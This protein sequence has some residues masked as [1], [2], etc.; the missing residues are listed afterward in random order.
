MYLRRIEVQGFKSFP[1]KTIVEFGA[2]LTALVGPNG[3]GKSNIADAIRWALGEQSARM[4]RAQRTEDVI[5]GG[6]PKRSRSGMAEVTLVFDNGDGWLPLEYG[7]VSV[8]RRA[9]RSGENDYI[10]NGSSVRLRDLQDLL[11]T[12]AMGV[13]GQVVVGQGQIDA[14]LRLKPEDRRTFI[15]EAAGVSRHYAK[16][17]EARR[18]LQRT[19]RNL[20]R[21]RDLHI[22]LVP[23][24]DQLKLQSEVA[25]RSRDLGEELESQTRDLLQ[26]R[27]AQAAESLES[28][29]LAQRAASEKL[30]TLEAARSLNTGD[31]ADHAVETARSRLAKARVVLEKIRADMTETSAGSRLARQ[32]GQFGKRAITAFSAREAGSS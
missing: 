29:K 13:N 31:S 17:D 22:E 8:T 32:R 5:F 27:L 12:A 4:L 20:E 18:R 19:E 10:L 24:L 3:A 16:R 26:H 21:L 23:R 6:T 2:G 15:E 30:A 1:R 7:E 28:A 14:I 9:Y 25:E 11:R